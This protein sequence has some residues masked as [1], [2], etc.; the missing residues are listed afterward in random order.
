MLITCEGGGVALARCGLDEQ[1]EEVE[2]EGPGEAKTWLGDFF[3]HAMKRNQSHRQCHRNQTGRTPWF[4]YS[5]HIRAI[6]MSAFSCKK[7]IESG[8]LITIREETFAE[9]RTYETGTSSHQCFFRKLNFHFRELF[10][11]SFFR[12]VRL[13]Q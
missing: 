2:L 4:L 7:I 13:A 6:C 8:D 11:C 12:I 10:D 3:I 1:R 5:T 9:V